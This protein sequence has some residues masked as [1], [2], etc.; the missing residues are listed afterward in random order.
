MAHRSSSSA[1]V[2]HAYPWSSDEGSLCQECLKIPPS[3]FIPESNS[4]HC[5]YKGDKA[6]ERIR[7]SIQT[8][9]HLCTLIYDAL[10]AGQSPKAVTI[11]MHGIQL[12]AEWTLLRPREP[13]TTRFDSSASTHNNHLLYGHISPWTQPNER[14]GP[15][16]R[17]S[18]GGSNS[19]LRFNFQQFPTKAKVLHVPNWDACSGTRNFQFDK[20]PASLA[21]KADSPETFQLINSWLDQCQTDHGVRCAYVGERIL[22]T[23]YS[24]PK[25]LIRV[26]NE[27][28]TP[29]LVESAIL[30]RDSGGFG[31]S[32]TALSHC[33]GDPKLV[34]KTTK[35][36]LVQ[37][38]LIGLPLERMPTTFQDAINITRK[39]RVDFL[40]ID[41]LCIVQDDPIDKTRELAAMDLIY[42]MAISV[43]VASS[44]PDG[45]LGCFP[46]RDS[47]P[48]VHVRPYTIGIDERKSN[49][50]VTFQPYLADWSQS[51]T[52]GPLF[53]RGWCFQ[54]R[55]V[56]KRII[57]FTKTQILWE[58]HTAI[59]SEAY[60][61]LKPHS[62]LRESPVARPF[63][64]E[65]TRVTDRTMLADDPRRA[66]RWLEDW[67]HIVEAYSDKKLSVPGD[68]LPAL[69][70]IAAFFENKMRGPNQ[71]HSHYVAGIW[72]SGLAM[73][74]SWC[75]EL[76][77]RAGPTRNAAW[78]PPFKDPTTYGSLQQS[79]NT[80][81]TSWLPS[82]SWISAN[83]AVRYYYSD[84]ITYAPSPAGVMLD[85]SI[86]GGLP[87]AYFPLEVH[88]TIVNLSSPNSF[89]FGEVSLGA[90][91]L[92]SV[93]AEV[94]ITEKN[95]ITDSKLSGDTLKCYS[96]FKR[97]F[98]PFNFAKGS[99]PF[100]GGAIF[101]DVNPHNLPETTV[102]CLR[103]G[104]GKSLLDK[105]EGVVEFGIAL[106]EVDTV[107]STSVLDF[108]EP[109]LIL[110]RVGLFEVDVWNKRWPK[111]ASKQYVY[112]I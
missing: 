57:H 48:D 40:W 103:L 100:A 60:P 73:G 78:P 80:A 91:I 111:V 47:N 94:T 97:S 6:V 104:T 29:M 92:S 31:P 27:G 11:D 22:E 16:L 71:L 77:S 64:M 25:R 4:S 66:G 12:K 41:S 82:W 34:P 50:S 36:T 18:W 84:G 15:L 33:W 51:I 54:E 85:N 20:T 72:H 56:A 87:T 7:A 79:S 42:S 75:P 74:L 38:M 107:V 96:M 28:D 109:F 65:W 39:L 3:L 59:A 2:Q 10:E 90:L 81:L 112:V 1:T 70:G 110:R 13:K 32:Y 86:A 30:G 26:G 17:L 106:I 14:P 63:R 5:M 46:P 95:L 61:V 62:T 45:Q 35:E 108:T 101:F 105:A 68:R 52:S 58:C 99:S 23:N 102:Y 24:S 89:K 76:A 43:L 88:G 53:K 83:D 93:T 67:L 49:I 9:C 19:H 8:G 69:A 37:F 55:Q 98:N 44:S 21:A